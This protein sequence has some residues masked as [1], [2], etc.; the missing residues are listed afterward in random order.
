MTKEKRSSKWTFLLYP[1]SAPKHYQ[2]ILN[3]MQVPWILSPKHDRDVNIKTGE[4]KKAH[5]HGALFFESLK[6]YSQ[7][8]ELV[9]ENLHSP[10]HVEVVMSPKGMYDYFTHA[11]NPEK[12][13]YEISNIES[14]AGFDLNKFLIEQNADTYMND[15]I[16][17][18]EDNDFTEF[19]ELVYYARDNNY[20][21]LTLIVDHTSFFSKYLDSRRNNPKRKQPE[22]DT[23][24]KN[25]N[26]K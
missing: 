10:E 9:S 13:Q 18:I 17:I 12:T 5:R 21:L 16:D 14:G 7:V 24:R 15:V 20:S 1:E 6:S 22:I 4:L 26:V 19:E 3:K 8:S 11:E 25:S 23:N 2:E